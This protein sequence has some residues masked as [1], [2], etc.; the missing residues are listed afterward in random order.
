MLRID[1]EA[2]SSVR[3]DDERRI[4]A[5]IGNL[6]GNLSGIVCSDYNKGVL[7]SRVLAAAFKSRRHPFTLVDPKGRDFGRY[8]G[9]DLLTPNEKELMEAAADD[10]PRMHEDEVIVARAE[11]VMKNVGLNA[12]LVTRGSRG[13]DLFEVQKKHI[14]RTHIAAIQR[15]EVFDVTGAGDTVAAVVCMTA[16]SGLPLSDAARLANAAAG[17]VVG[18]IG[19]AVADSETLAR[20]VGGES[21]QAGAKV[22]SRAALATRMADA[23]AHGATI[24][25][26]SGSFDVLDVPLLRALQRARAEGDLLVVGV[27][28]KAASQRAEML[29]ALRFVDYVTVFAE[30]TPARLIREMKPD[31][32]I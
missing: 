18:T 30:P 7:S 26:T 29:A 1:R 10:D 2:R 13:M 17:I 8:R 12:L 28:G 31:V 5:A 9:A 11:S 19:T 27:N 22:L 4:I 24:V 23:R 25:F 14:R 16:S 15:H 6:R 21:S 32:V 20:I 3:A